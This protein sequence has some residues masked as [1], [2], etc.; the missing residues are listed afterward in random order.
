MSD[1]STAASVSASS[2]RSLAEAKSLAEHLPDLLVEARR[3]A[4]S[5]LAGW[6]GRRRA[7]PGENF[8]QFRPFLAG[9]P[10]ARI[11]WRRSARDDHLYIRERE[12]E[13]AHT[14]WIWADR[15]PSM[16]YVSTLALQSKMDR[17]LVLSL[18]AA[19]LLVRGGERVGAPGLLRPVAARNI[20]D[21]MA[22]ALVQQ[23]RRGHEDEELPPAEPLAPL[24]ALTASSSLP[25]IPE[26]RSASDATALSI[27]MIDESICPL[28]TGTSFSPNC[29]RPAM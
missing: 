28:Q 13:A 25:T 29:W 11:D 22:E 19:D 26:K 8:W 1:R 17:A 15:S 24:E 18:A 6:H 16:A 14:V 20:V 3:V 4:T 7:G 23:A 9:E 10:P 2:G 5:V 12:W 21:R 27:C